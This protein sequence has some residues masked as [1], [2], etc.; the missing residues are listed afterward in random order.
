M[1]T[2]RVI[3]ESIQYPHA[4]AAFICVYEPPLS[5]LSTGR[6]LT[7]KNGVL[8]LVLGGIGQLGIHW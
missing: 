5:A 1:F 2:S 4:P 8:L 7:S 3:N 6:A